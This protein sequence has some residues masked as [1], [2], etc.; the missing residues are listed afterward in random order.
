M[1]TNNL[2]E[3]NARQFQDGESDRDGILAP[4]TR[5]EKFKKVQAILQLEVGLQQLRARTRDS[6][7]NKQ[8]SAISTT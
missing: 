6:T 8:N 1:R 4:K 3:N 5:H 7:E 2:L